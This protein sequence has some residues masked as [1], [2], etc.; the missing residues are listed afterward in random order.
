MAAPGL[1]AG[2]KLAQ[3][4]EMSPSS[5]PH[6][7]MP[8]RSEGPCL[9]PWWTGWSRCTYVP[10]RGQGWVC[11]A[12]KNLTGHLAPSPGVPGAWR[13]HT[14]LGRALLDS[15]LSRQMRLHRLQLLA[16]P[17][18]SWRDKWTV[19]ASRGTYGVGLGRVEPF[20]LLHGLNTPIAHQGQG[21]EA[22]VHP[23]LFS[24]NPSL[25][26]SAPCLL[27][28]A[29]SPRAELLRAERP[30]LRALG[31]PA[32]TTRTATLPRATRCP[33]RSTHRA[34]PA[35]VG[36]WLDVLPAA[37]A[38]AVWEPGRRAAAA[39]SLAPS[40]LEGVG[41]D[42]SRQFTGM[43]AAE[44]SLV[45][46]P[47]FLCRLLY[48]LRV[49][50]QLEGRRSES[51][52][53]VGEMRCFSQTEG[54]T[55][56][57]LG[58]VGGQG[59]SSF[60]HG[61]SVIRCLPILSSHPSLPPPHPGGRIRGSAPP[62]RPSF[63]LDN[64]P[65]VPTSRELLSSPWDPI[66]P[67]L[68]ASSSRSEDSVLPV[69]RYSCRCLSFSPLDLVGSAPLSEAR[70][71]PRRYLPQVARPQRHGTSL[72][73]AR[74]LRHPRPAPPLSLETSSKN[75]VCVQF[76]IPPPGGTGGLPSAAH[77][78]TGI[79]TQMLEECQVQ[80][81][82]CW[83]GTCMGLPGKNGGRRKSSLTT[84][85]SQG[86][87]LSPQAFLRFPIPAR[88]L[89]LDFSGW[90]TLGPT[91]A[92]IDLSP[93]LSRDPVTVG[94]EALSLSY[95]PASGKGVGRRVWREECGGEKG[96]GPAP[97]GAMRSCSGPQ[98]FPTMQRGALSPVLMLTAAPD[99][100]RARLP[101]F[102]PA[103]SWAPPWVGSVQSAPEPSGGLVQ[104]STAACG[105]PWRLR[106][107]G[108]RCYRERSVREAIGNGARA[109]PEAFP[110]PPSGPATSRGHPLDESSGAWWRTRRWN[111]VGGEE[112]CICDREE[113]RALVS[114]AE[115]SWR[116]KGPGWRL[117]IRERVWESRMEGAGCGKWTL[118][119]HLRT[120]ALES[121]LS[122]FFAPSSG[123]AIY[124]ILIGRK[125]GGPGRL[126]TEKGRGSLYRRP[127]SSRS[128]TDPGASAACLLHGARV[129]SQGAE[130]QQGNF[131]ATYHPRRH[132]LLPPGHYARACATCRR[133][134]AGAHSREKGWAEDT[135]RRFSAELLQECCT[136]HLTLV[137]ALREI[138]GVCG[139]EVGGGQ[140][141]NLMQAWQRC[142]T[143]AL[144][145]SGNTSCAGEPLKAGDNELSP[146]AP[147]LPIMTCQLPADTNVLRYIRADSS[148]M[149]RCSLQ[150]EDSGARTGLCGCH[151]L[152]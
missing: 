24:P 58:L 35:V 93:H 138:T 57:S 80:V 112:G 36:A 85:P 32:C 97:R 19:R 20:L 73:A 150:R 72:A 9:A 34:W 87:P 121:P 124:S 106:G 23:H 116:L 82:A 136:T 42:P 126:S 147:G 51:C 39:L 49:M 67:V 105:P 132:C 25:P 98:E 131:K 110:P 29:P 1:D 94:P 52:F 60:F 100:R 46:G 30:I 151:W 86:P 21:V 37:M 90:P 6:Q 141:P 54:P 128:S 26:P 17:A 107:R 43:A 129:L 108:P 75:T 68:S 18:C 62:R 140:T 125:L 137:L 102:P 115:G 41:S 96:W 144:L 65:R 122:V 133:P 28:A 56:F 4:C 38:A 134:A 13:G 47:D 79:R 81:W 78:V 14:L 143:R 15:Y 127:G 149:N 45:S 88:P 118:G 10:R 11:I 139:G 95:V 104:R 142:D 2:E 71:L 44:R 120:S 22:G 53:W 8:A 146:A 70:L 61:A 31:F 119:C 114:L 63:T 113:V 83:G 27:G 7:V 130:K 117:L 103:G 152:S 69:P 74:L 66:Q 50:R 123:G 40:V 5:T 109:R 89:C 92:F 12:N 91:V 135:G 111:A 64:G 145:G 84:S 99:L 148:E 33:G 16:W 48:H 55:C 101:P 76:C 3:V 77:G 59:E